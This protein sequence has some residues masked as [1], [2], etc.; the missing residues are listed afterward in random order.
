[1]LLFLLLC[2]LLL[3]LLLLPPLAMFRQQQPQ[4]ARLS[5]LASLQYR[6]A[7]RAL[8]WA[9]AWQQQRLEQSTLHVGRSQQQA[10]SW[11]LQ[12][13]QGPCCPLRGSTGVFPRVWGRC[14]KDKETPKDSQI[15]EPEDLP[16]PLSAADTEGPD[17][18]TR[19]GSGLL[20]MNFPILG[21]ESPFPQA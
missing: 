14:P 17:P 2:L 11:C 19:P 5:W 6:V 10:L 4:D 20:K 18:E 8:C 13:A 3:L 12:R 7:W 21:P 1:M 16:S 15:P 9:A